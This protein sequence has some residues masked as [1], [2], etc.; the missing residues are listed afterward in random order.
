MQRLLSRDAKC[1]PRLVLAAAIMCAAGCTSKTIHVEGDAMAPAF[2]NGETAIA[3][4]VVDR[5]DRGEVVAFRY[6]LDESKSFIKRIVGLPGEQI[7]MKNGQ[8][9][10]NGRQLDEPYVDAANRSVD[11]RAPLAIPEGE[12]FVLGDNRRN[13]SDSRHWGN[14]RRDLIWGKV[15]E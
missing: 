2:K 4:L 8:V 10:V 6:P 1:W 3:T 7:E 11:S 13:S 12:Y 9:F 5:L 14:V 15:P